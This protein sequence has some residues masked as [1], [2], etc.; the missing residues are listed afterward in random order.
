LSVLQANG[1]SASTFRASGDQDLPAK[2][3]PHVVHEPR[4]VH[5]FDHRPHARGLEAGAEMAQAVGVRWRRGLRD[6]LA[7]VVEQSDVE[8]TST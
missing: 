6:Q 8:P 1:A 5:R 4:G 7:G 3:L 2:R